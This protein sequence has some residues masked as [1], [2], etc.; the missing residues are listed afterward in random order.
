LNKTTR[1]DIPNVISD[2][3]IRERA[4]P[5]PTRTKKQTDD[6]DAMF[7]PIGPLGQA[8]ACYVHVEM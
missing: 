7:S 3:E 5:T 2:Q 8:K 1:F 4:N 6:L